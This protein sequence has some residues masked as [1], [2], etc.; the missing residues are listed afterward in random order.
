MNRL[1]FDPHALDQMAV[2]KLSEDAV[3]HVIEDHDRR[4][5][6]DDGVTE[7]VG[8]WEGRDLM[9]VVRWTDEHEDDGHVITV[10]D[11]N[12]RRWRRR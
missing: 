4:I 6:R 2:R 5:D 3:Y 9:V 10:I 11:T 1:A 7:Y 8:T 12:T